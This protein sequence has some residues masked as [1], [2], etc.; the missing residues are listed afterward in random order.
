VADLVQCIPAVYVVEMFAADVLIFHMVYV[1]Y[2]RLVNN[3][4]LS[5]SKKESD[6]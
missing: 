1:I 6:K 5:K 4:F 2:A 3:S